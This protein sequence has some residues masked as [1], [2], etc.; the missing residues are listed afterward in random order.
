M[1]VINR[2]DKLVEVRGKATVNA[3]LVKVCENIYCIYLCEHH[4]NKLNIHKWRY[5]ME[6]QEF[7]LVICLKYR[8]RILPLEHEIWHI[9][10]THI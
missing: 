10:S 9:F 8:R 4:N 5:N 3:R 6:K 1:R 2:E 7:D